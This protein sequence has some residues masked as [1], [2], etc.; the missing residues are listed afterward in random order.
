MPR[1]DEGDPDR[2]QEQEGR[3][4]QQLEPEGLEGGLDAGG[5]DDPDHNRQGGAQEKSP[6][7]AQDVESF[8]E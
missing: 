8:T 2:P 1:Q 5:V 6:G 7:V 3:V 4:A